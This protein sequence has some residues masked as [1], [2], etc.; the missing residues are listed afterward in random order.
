MTM[1][2]DE[3]VGFTSPVDNPVTLVDEQKVVPAFSTYTSAMLDM[4]GYQ[5]V[6]VRLNLL[7]AGG[8]DNAL[9]TDPWDLE[10]NWFNDAAGQQPCYLDSYQAFAVMNQPNNRALLITD[11]IHG[12]YLQVSADDSVSSGR[13]SSIQC[14]VVGSYRAEPG[15][16]TRQ[17][18]TDAAQGIVYEGREIAVAAGAS[19]SRNMRFAYGRARLYAYTA[20]GGGMTITINYGD[21]F[22]LDK[23]VIP[24][25][26]QFAATELILP[27]K[28]GRITVTNNGAAAQDLVCMVIQEL[29]LI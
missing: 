6:L 28:Q 7:N 12:A 29:N 18:A 16:F 22:A 21:S 20:A 1:S 5:S 4:R 27:K 9:S 2:F 17:W 25:A 13:Q 8:G 26:N 23:L 14:R 19:V 3:A 10:L 24:G 11:T 15:V